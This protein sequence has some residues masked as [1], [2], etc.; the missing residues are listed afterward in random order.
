MDK[1]GKELELFQNRERDLCS[2][3]AGPE[4]LGESAGCCYASLGMLDV[5]SENLKSLPTA[6]TRKKM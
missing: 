2:F 5:K 3:S 6:R 1:E 4:G